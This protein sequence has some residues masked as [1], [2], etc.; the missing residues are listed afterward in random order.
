MSGLADLLL[1]MGHTVSGSDRQLSAL[2]DYLKNRGVKIVQGHHADHV[3]DADFVIYSSAIPADNPEMSRA[4]EKGIPRI[5]RAELLGQ[6][7]LRKLGIAVGGT[8]GKTTTTSI[9]GEILIRAGLD[10]TVVVG[11]RMRSSMT[12]ARLGKGE[13]LVTEADEY[14]RS[15]LT[16]YPRIAVLT[17]LETDHLDIYKDLED[18]RT[19]FIQFAN[20]TSFDGSVVCYGDDPN[21]IQIMPEI[22]RTMITYGAGGK[23]D[24]RCDNLNFEGESSI[25][26]ALYG[27]DILGEV[28]LHVPGRHNVMNA[29]AAIA[30]C[31]ELDIPFSKIKRGIEEFEGV[32]RRFQ[33]KG[34]VNGISFFDDYAHHPSEIRETLSAAKEGWN[35]RIVA[36]FQ[37]HLYSRT[38]DFYQEFASELS[39]ADEV[40]ITGIYPAREEP[41]EGVTSEC[42][43]KALQDKGHKRV[44]YLEDKE[45]LPELLKHHIR[46][47]DMVITMGAG[48]I[49]YYGEKALEASK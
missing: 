45:A 18:L 46:P 43:V 31:R 8:H 6:F 5:R 7:M 15:F 30:V 44:H 20:Q 24:Y 14:D 35:R 13:I 4:R 42:I 12:N 1:E 41:I 19:T 47:G 16:L 28:H 39:R 33:L 25:F 29:L 11:G 37:P 17:S 34:T 23:T 48:D 2:T 49:W 9:I 10:P 32:E 38:R 36:I 3:E 27:E 22:Q 21:L 40:F 26:R